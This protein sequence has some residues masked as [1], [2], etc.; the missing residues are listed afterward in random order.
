MM[1]SMSM[2]TDLK[3]KFIRKIATSLLLKYLD[4]YKTDIARLVQ[5]VNMIIAALYL[6]M[7]I[8]DQH[9]GTG[10]AQNLDFVNEKWLLALQFITHLGLEVGIQDKKAKNKLDSK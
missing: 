1:L 5:A 9:F 4:G 3:D 10:F 6:S 2:I 8:L 7:P